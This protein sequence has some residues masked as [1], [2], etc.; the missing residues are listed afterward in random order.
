MEIDINNYESVL[1]DYFDGN[2]NALEVAEVLLFLEQHP[3]IKNEFEALGNLPMAENIVIESEFKLNLKKLNHH[4]T[5]ANKSFNELII[6]QIEGDCTAQENLVINELVEENKSLS[7]LKQAFLLTKLIPDLTLK[8]P[9]KQALK[10]KEAIVFY[11]N[12]KLAFAATLLLL[13]S[14]LFFIY[15]NTNNT[16]APLEVAQSKTNAQGSIQQEEEVKITQTPIEKNIATTLKQPKANKADKLVAKTNETPL[17]ASSTVPI[18]EQLNTLAIKPIS[19]L[20]SS[21]AL[22]N[23]SISGQVVAVEMLANNESSNEKNFLTL[24]N[25]LKKKIIERGKDNLIENEK[26]KSN[27]ELAIDPLTVA[28]VGAD[29]FE[30]TTGKKVFLTRSFDKQ[31]SIK[32]YTLSAGNFKFERIK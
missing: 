13:V 29:I 30:K 6:S 7:K 24:G 22:E 4:E 14:H 23:T 9:N 19:G 25:F 3:E 15:R 28:S 18:R 31:G 12:R 21:V 20:A 26:P 5:L 17:E 2:L 10:R 8:F 11:L 32:S 1:I 16:I 27:D